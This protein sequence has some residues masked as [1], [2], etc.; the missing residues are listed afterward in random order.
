MKHHFTILALFSLLAA[1]P[2]Y[3]QSSLLIART[4]I[5]V[6][7]TGT[8][9]SG[10][11]STLTYNSQLLTNQIKTWKIDSMGN[12]VLK[13]RLTDY[14]YDANGNLLYFLD[15]VGNDVNG[16]AD[17]YRYNYTYD[18][19]GRELSYLEE[20]WNGTAWV[21][22]NSVI[23]VY[24]ANGN[25]LSE[26]RIN[27]RV[28]FTYDAQ[29]LL[30]TKTGQSF[31][32]GN[33]VD[34]TRVDYAYL[35]NST[36]GTTYN[37]TNNAWKE[38]SRSTDTFDGSGNLIQNLYEQWNGTAWENNL[39]ESFNFDANGNIV[40]DMTQGWNG[41]S[42]DNYFMTD[43]GYDAENNLTFWT[44][45]NW[46][47]IDSTWEGSIRQFNGYD[48][49]NHFIS[50][51]LELWDGVSW[52]LISYGDLYY[53]DFVSTHTAVL[54]DFEIFPNPASSAVTIKG[55]GLSQVMVFDQQG[56]PIRRQNLHGQEEETL[57]LGHLPAGNY[58]L[59]VLGN[60][61]KMVA[62]PLQIRH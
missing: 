27:S 18:I 42:W 49:Q 10:D 60:D 1:S 13:F 29:N 28:I 20:K 47:D 6:D 39:L 56:R 62:K 59:Q 4:F 40:Q 53:A 11:S 44:S 37:W 22:Q 51:Q 31:V 50:A 45:S 21:T 14:S 2:V 36:T 33:W 61:G 16:W 38:S 54:A 57:Q 7:A 46:V 17:A 43:Y 25:L 26:T 3:G 52:F 35:P 41:T 34:K 24:D 23:R 48:A 9:Y 19:D 30:Q 58:I 5:H 55:E 15:Q 32:A 8:P 12:W